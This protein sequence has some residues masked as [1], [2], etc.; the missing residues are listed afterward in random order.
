MEWRVQ[1][2]HDDISDLFQGWDFEICI[3]SG[4]YLVAQKAHI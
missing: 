2:G 3:N 4:G 1:F